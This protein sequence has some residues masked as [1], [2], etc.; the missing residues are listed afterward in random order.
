MPTETLKLVKAPVSVVII[1]K[2]EELRLPDCLRSVAGWAGE[3][4]I[5][6]DMSTDK[7]VDVAGKFTDKIFK[8]AMD[9]E[10]RHRNYAYN[11]ATQDWVLSLDADERVTPE[12][13]EEIAKVTREP[14]NPHICYAIPIKTFIGSEWI[15]GAGHYPAA[16]TRLFR[17]GKFRYEEAS[18]HPRVIYEGS[19]GLLKG[20]I[21]HYSA[22]DLT[23]W[24]AKFNRE[25]QLEAEKWVQDGRKVSLPK[26]LRKTFDRF[27]KNYFLK[28]GWKTGFLGFL[29]SVFHGLY[30]LFT[31]AKY[32]ELKRQREEKA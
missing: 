18:V 11:L 3:I 5:L 9:I 19:C 8:R 6:D 2:N 22:K 25:T 27:F 10:G 16:K 23:Q 14:N 31:Y 21:L 30:Q 1:A 15:E 32:R 7:T 28:R 17:K 12:L 29:M 20:D 13:A 24:I 26:T 4:V